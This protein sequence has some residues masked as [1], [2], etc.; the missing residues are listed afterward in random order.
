MSRTDAHLPHRL[1]RPEDL[2]R[3]HETCLTWRS[4]VRWPHG[5]E[6]REMTSP[7]RN[8]DR[9][10]LRRLAGQLDADPQLATCDCGRASGHDQ[11]RGDSGC[12]GPAAQ[13][14]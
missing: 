12:P 9:R 7:A 1:V 10:A 8:S 5:F 14:P 6:H 2:P 11:L 3:R 4:M 13:S